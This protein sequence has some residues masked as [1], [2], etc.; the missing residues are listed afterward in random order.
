MKTNIL[1]LPAFFALVSW[2]LGGVTHAGAE[3]I[4]SSLRAPREI[5]TWP[6]EVERIAQ[7][8]Y[9]NKVAA[10]AKYNMRIAVE[11]EST[12]KRTL[13]G[14]I[15]V[16]DMGALAAVTDSELLENAKSL[17]SSDF[18]A[19]LIVLAHDRKNRP[20]AHETIRTF[21]VDFN[22]DSGM[23]RPVNV[24]SPPV[25]PKHANESW[26]HPLEYGFFAPPAGS[27]PNEDTARWN[28]YFA[29]IQLPT[30]DKTNIL[31]LAD[32]VSAEPYIGSPGLKDSQILGL[33]YLVNHP[34]QTNSAY[35][36]SMLA[37]ANSAHYGKAILGTWIYPFRSRNKEEG[38]TAPMEA[39]ED[40]ENTIPPWDIWIKYFKENP[41]EREKAKRLAELFEQAAAD[42]EKEKK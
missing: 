37:G 9:S 28:L 42:A 41:A 26:L 16:E 4:P 22:H 23:L 20:E 31:M 40:V 15:F 3:E 25:L 17:E 19:K 29:L 8:L 24:S 27:S 21:Y 38:P 18:I 32:A 14:K 6:P 11:D 13:R 36:E 1:L 2:H 5:A 12:H 30:R 33:Q 39:G 34:N 35:L 7:K 10:M